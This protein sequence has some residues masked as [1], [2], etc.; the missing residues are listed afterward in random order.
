VRESVC[1]ERVCVCGES[2]CVCGERERDGEREHEVRNLCSVV[3]GHAR[4]NT[5]GL[6]R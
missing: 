3:E 6:E 1:G 5:L 4:R 2:V